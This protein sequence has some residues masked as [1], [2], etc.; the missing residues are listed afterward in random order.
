MFDCWKYAPVFQWLCIDNPFK[1]ERY[2]SVT[3]IHM[4]P[5][6]LVIISSVLNPLQRI[7]DLFLAAWSYIMSSTRQLVGL[8]KLLIAIV[9]HCRRHLS[10]KES[11]QQS[12]HTHFY[13]RYFPRADIGS[14]YIYAYW[15]VLW[16][17]T[18]FVVH[19]SSLPLTVF[20]PSVSRDVAET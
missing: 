14:W 18:N 8:I 20:W 17:W 3:F 2:F 6:P 1:V 15:Y 5:D 7:L 11:N 13:R 12:E 4:T 10:V 16:G 19:S 9:T